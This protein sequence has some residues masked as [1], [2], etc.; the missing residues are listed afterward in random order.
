[1]ASVR[2]GNGGGWFIEAIKKSFGIGNDVG[3]GTFWEYLWWVSGG[4]EV[5]EVKD[6][7]VE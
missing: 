3:H 1:M 2:F 6:A 7:D 5:V 4:F